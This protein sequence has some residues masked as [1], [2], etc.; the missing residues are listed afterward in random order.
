M[1]GSGKQYTLHNVLPLNLEYCKICH[2]ND[3]L[4]LSWMKQ[5]LCRRSA[6]KLD[7][8]LLAIKPVVEKKHSTGTDAAEIDRCNLA[9]G[10]DEDVC[11]A[12]HCC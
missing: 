4:Q 10:T 11:Q 6:D 5:I 2:S 7:R 12:G 9:V 8:L 3:N 1:D